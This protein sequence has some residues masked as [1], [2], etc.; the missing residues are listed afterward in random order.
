MMSSCTLDSHC[1]VCFM[2]VQALRDG[3]FLLYIISI[4]SYIVILRAYDNRIMVVLQLLSYRLH[5][6]CDAFA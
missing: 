5:I 3:L 6:I 4:L 2:E 1:G